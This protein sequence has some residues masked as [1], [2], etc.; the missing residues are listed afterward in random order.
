MKNL[1]LTTIALLL[2]AVIAPGQIT[3]LQT[4]VTKTAAFNGAP[5]DVSALSGDFTIRMTATKLTV[6]KTALLQLQEV[7]A[8]DFTTPNVAWTVQL[9]G[10]IQQQQVFTVRSY[11]LPNTVARAWGKTNGKFRF[12]LAAIDGSASIN[13]AAWLEQ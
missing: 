13:Y 9:H 5:L 3:E 8:A 7:A 12:C 2:L 6:G 11:Q 1:T 4:P 10:Q